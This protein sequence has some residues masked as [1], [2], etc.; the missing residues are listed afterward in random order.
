MSA[1]LG[2]YLHIPFCARKCN[3]CDF[4]S[5]KES[6][7][8]RRSYVSALVSHLAAMA[9]RARDRVI[10]TVYFGG[11]TPTMLSP[12]DFSRIMD[13]VRA[14]FTLSPHAEITTEC[15]PVTYT[16]G[17]FEGLL[18]AGIN[19]VSIGLQST[20]AKELSLLGR[21][22]TADD[23]YHTLA[24]ARRAGVANISA[25]VMFGIPAQTPRS[26]AETLAV[27]CDLSPEHISAYGLRIEEGTP[28]HT[29][30]DTL[31]FPD[32]DAEAEMAELV[33]TYLPSRGYDRYEI[34]NY[35]RNGMESRHNL[36]YWQG[37]E[38]LGFGPA[39]HSFFEGVRYETP[40]DTAAYIAAVTRGD[41]DSLVSD[42]HVLTAHEAREE[43]TMLRLRLSR[44][45]DKLDFSHRFGISFGDAYGDLTPLVKGGFLTDD[46]NR[47]AFTARG[48][49]VSNAILSD[50]LDFGGNV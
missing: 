29:M 7:D 3:Y 19:R 10:D 36:R 21:L 27:L 30:R 24:A 5:A 9:P 42:P 6:A 37:E 18:A 11:G 49:Q 2:L 31:P 12:A 40:A 25:D 46:G 26:F 34:S 28:F 35:A 45:I 8:T 14:C 20:N 23:F 17:L 39:A 13:T 43:Y 41:T 47:I 50:L 22:H 48:M 38:Y 16:D 4:C 33:S 15:N 32:E 44:G 1:T